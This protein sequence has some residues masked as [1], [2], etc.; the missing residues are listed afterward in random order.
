MSFLRRL[1]SRPQPTDAAPVSS[2]ADLPKETDAE[3]ADTG[4]KPETPVHVIGD[5]HGR[6]DLLETLLT[7]LDTEGAGD[8]AITVLLGDY[9]NKGNHSRDVLD[10]VVERSFA[11]PDRFICLLGNHEQMLLDF[12]NRPM[13]KGRN[14]IAQSGNKTLESYGIEPLTEDADPNDIVKASRALKEALGTRTLRWLKKR[15]TTWQSGSLVVS[16][17]GLD[18][19]KSV[20]DQSENTPLWGHD[21]FQT[22]PRSDGLWVITGHVEI[23]T[24]SI[25]DNRIAIDTKAYSSGT[26]TAAVITPDGVVNFLQT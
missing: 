10:L 11:E 19:A 13:Q 8:G 15:P 14:W 21:D 20:A 23:D 16:H 25:Q 18:P 1:F 4:P 7:R 2:D 9:V 3:T 17:A 12:V 5:V 26:L 22:T 6:I 24:P